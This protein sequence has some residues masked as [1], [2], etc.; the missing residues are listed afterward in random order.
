MESDWGGTV[1]NGEDVAW[2]SPGLLILL[3]ILYVLDISNSV[4]SKKVAEK[5]GR[6]QLQQI[7][8]TLLGSFSKQS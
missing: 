1:V 8:E 4:V 7:H 3:R 2:G 6:P 5:L